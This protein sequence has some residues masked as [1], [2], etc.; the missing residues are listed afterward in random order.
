MVA[1][2]IVAV[3]VKILAQLETPTTR[4]Q[5][6]QAINTRNNFFNLS[7][8]PQDSS[9]FEFTPFHRIRIGNYLAK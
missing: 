9:S 8:I 3:V 4:R 2:V 6:T 1:R 7:N 5:I